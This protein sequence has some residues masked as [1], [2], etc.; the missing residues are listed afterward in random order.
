MIALGYTLEIAHE[1]TPK[2]REVNRKPPK[3]CAFDARW[4]IA[5]GR[6]LRWP[7]KELLFCM[8]WGFPDYSENTRP[9]STLSPH[10]LKA[11]TPGSGVLEA[12]EKEVKRGWIRPAMKFPP[13]IP[14]RVNPENVEPKRDGTARVV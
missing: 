6:A 11:M 13:S 9:I 14:F 3:A 2:I 1:G 4:I 7:D 12:W 8:E 5:E 10:Q